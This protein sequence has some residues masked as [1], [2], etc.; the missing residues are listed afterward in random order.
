MKLRIVEPGWEF[1][2]GPFSGVMFLNGVSTRDVTKFEEDRIAAS[3]RVVSEDGQAVGA[4]NDIIRGKDLRAE[5]VPE[6]AR[7]DAESEKVTVEA[8]QEPPVAKKVSDDK[9][10]TQEE[11]E[12][13]ADSRGIAGLREIGEPLGVRS[14]S[15]KEL[16]DGIIK[17][18]GGQTSAE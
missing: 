13:V 15:I 12:S 3:V 10:W 17:A 8:V 9:V 18:Q 11:L 6:S 16:I 7:A 4:A 1:Y 14:K 2:T 5:V